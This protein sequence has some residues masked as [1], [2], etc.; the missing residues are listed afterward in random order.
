MHLFGSVLLLSWVLSLQLLKGAEAKKNPPSHVSDTGKSEEA[1]KYRQHPEFNLAMSN[2]TYIEWET[3][4]NMTHD[5]FNHAGELKQLAKML[6][7]EIDKT[8]I[9]VRVAEDAAAKC[10]IKP[11][12]EPLPTL[13]GAALSTR[14]PA[15]KNAPLPTGVV[16]HVAELH[17]GDDGNTYWVVK[18]WAKKTGTEKKIS[19]PEGIDPSEHFNG[20][21]TPVDPIFNPERPPYIKVAFNLVQEALR[22]TERLQTVLRERKSYLIQI[23]RQVEKYCNKKYLDQAK[24]PHPTTPYPLITGSVRTGKSH[25]FPVEW[26]EHEKGMPESAA[27]LE[28]EYLTKEYLTKE[29]LTNG[30]V[31]TITSHRKTHVGVPQVLP[32]RTSTTQTAGLPATYAPWKGPPPD[33]MS[34]TRLY[35]TSVH[36]AQLSASIPTPSPTNRHPA[37]A[38]RFAPL[39]LSVLEEALRANYTADL[40]RARATAAQTPVELWPE[41]HIEPL[42]TFSSTKTVFAPHT[43]HSDWQLVSSGAS[44]TARLGYEGVVALYPT[45]S[46][47]GE[48]AA[49]LSS[50]ADL[51]P[52]AHR[53]AGGS[54]GGKK[55]LEGWAIALIVVLV[56]LVLSGVGGAVVWAR[57]RERKR[58]KSVRLGGLS[59][60]GRAM[61]GE[62]SEVSVKGVV[63][64][65]AGGSERSRESVQERS[66]EGERG[67]EVV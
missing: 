49:P 33:P 38:K 27:R 47:T 29:R 28:D 18:Y 10:G 64:E 36:W 11:V 5:M 17:E 14:W 6:H 46:R 1:W 52:A 25:P 9:K 4:N 61:A 50:F 53:E 67:R 56:V 57:R 22:E 63:F 26:L 55:H 20:S 23:H 31:T 60:T 21:V 32:P 35:H 42:P 2:E 44:A 30:H 40:A 66:Q 24:A 54:D 58:R 62:G 59:R 45:P 41:P 34:F 16:E 48:Q 51:D 37:P 13:K 7:A 43:A 65:M 8:H 15:D 3:M 39:E 19:A 12:F